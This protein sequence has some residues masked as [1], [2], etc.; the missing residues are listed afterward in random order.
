MPNWSVNEV[1]VYGESEMIDKIEKTSFDFNKIVPPPQA[2][3]DDTEEYCTICKS[4]EL[5]ALNDNHRRCTRCDVGSNIGGRVSHTGTTKE[6]YKQLNKAE[7]KLAKLW[8]KKYGTDSWYEWNCEHWGTKWDAGEVVMNR[9]DEK[10]L[11]AV[12]HTAWSPPVP[13]F[14]RLVED[15]DVMIDVVSDI[16]GSEGKWRES[17][18][19]EV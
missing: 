2:L 5:V 17:Y 19:K 13:I 18:G 3:I 8:L 16:E 10:T 11:T 14:E 15:Y 4:R 12:F 9:V 7:I 6:R 1:T